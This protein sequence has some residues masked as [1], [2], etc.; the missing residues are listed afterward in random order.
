MRRLSSFTALSA[1]CAG[2]LI[3]QTE[4]A[5]VP[6]IIPEDGSPGS[7]PAPK[8]KIIPEDEPANPPV[9]AV[10]SEEPVSPAPR[11][12]VI[13]EDPAP[14]PAAPELMPDPIPEVSVPEKIKTPEPA[15]QPAEEKKPKKEVSEDE[16]VRKVKAVT[17]ETKKPEPQVVKEAKPG[18]PISAKNDKN[19]RTLLLSI[20]APRGQIVDRNGLP[21]AQNKMA[22]FL[23]LQFGLQAE[24]PDAE[25]LR[26]AKPL[27]AYIQKHSP[28]GWD[29]KDETILEHYKNRRWLP[30]LAT[31][32]IPAEALNDAKDIVPQG[33]VVVPCYLR[34]YPHGRIAA[35]ILGE[36]GRAGGMTTN[37]IQNGDFI[38]PTTEGKG[39][40]E[41]RF[42]EELSGVPGK[43]N[44]VFS[45]TGEKV[46][47]EI[48]ERP[49]P[50]QTVV[51]SIDLE[52]QIICERVL[53]EKTRRGAFVVM[54]VTTGDVLAMASNPSYDP[55]LF[56][57]G[58]RDADYKKLLADPDKPLFCRAKNGT[59][60]PASTF[61]VLTALAALETGKVDAGTYYE[62]TSSLY[63]GDRY[64][65]NWNRKSSEGSMNVIDAIKRSCNTW[66]Y[67]A[68]LATGPSP[69]TSMATRFGLGE[70]SGLCLPDSK[71]FVPTP[72]WWKK[73]YR[74]NI[75]SGDLM[76]ICIGQ[77]ATLVTPLQDCAMM[78][79]IARGHSVPRARL[80]QQIQNLDGGIINFFPPEKKTELE[81]QP[82]S[83]RLVRA[84]MKAVV[85][86]S[87][88]TGKGAGNDYVK[89]SGKTGTAQWGG[90]KNGE[91]TYMAWFA[92]YMPSNNPQ[93]AFAAIYEGDPGEDQISGGRKV[94]PIIGEAFSEIYKR[95]KQRGDSLLGP[96]P[97]D[98]KDANGETVR[99]ARIAEEGASDERPKKAKPI[100]APPEQPAVDPAPPREG[101]LRALW[102]RIRGK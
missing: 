18:I 79:G 46:S 93:Y 53:R 90:I 40:L 13:P 35:H 25:V 94:A 98:E 41:Q 78:A 71:G 73:R 15:K 81:I 88:G 17:G 28:D 91:Q 21:L 42:N 49:K 87:D 34:T 30:L 48:V 43:V 47:E 85:E 75:T 63:V 38:W 64:F 102:R 62:C 10:P 80:V 50:G 97:P 68:S 24:Q 22:H 69:V 65:H 27:V 1:I 52:M 26:M 99:K 66:F 4:P 14:V 29:V 36:M 11:P 2:M 72:E 89:V 19:A 5:P 39:G 86:E 20:P 100:E 58:V 8:P 70:Q 92:G 55:N 12:K 96:L 9:P 76:N 82:E 51:T 33:V 37:A 60:P 45:A 84:G 44:I 54:D 95:K 77:G 56:A 3:A 32:P 57:F 101:G 23:G 16:P 7:V 31:R 67:Q 6:R 59:Y 61:K 83:L 74:S